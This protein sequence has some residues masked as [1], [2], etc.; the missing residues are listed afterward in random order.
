MDM[1]EL[2]YVKKGVLSK[3]QCQALINEYEQRANE[4]ELEKCYHAVTNKMTTS[5]YKRIELIPETENFN[6]IHNTI[7]QTIK[8]WIV[9]LDSFTSFHTAALKKSLRYSHMHRLMKYSEGEWI[10]PHV[11]WEEMIHGS[12]TVAL[13]DDYEG[14]DFCFWNGKHT[15]KL[16]AGDVMIFPAG[17]MWVH[18]VMPITKGIRY[19][20]N[21]FLQSLPLQERNRVGEMIWAIGH[22]ANIKNAYFYDQCLEDLGDEG[23]LFSAYNS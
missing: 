13:N 15:V 7:N 17:P 14:G 12:C 10:H 2:I 11:D 23:I 8:D 19:S 3:E 5:T 18:E 16:E 21:T 4:A 1:R 9:Y 22:S 6:L 20:T